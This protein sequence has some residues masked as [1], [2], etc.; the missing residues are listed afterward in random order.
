MQAILI[1][2]TIINL[3]QIMTVRFVENSPDVAHDDRCSI[4]FASDPGSPYEIYGNDAREIY[5]RVAKTL[6]ITIEKCE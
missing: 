4:V 1:R 6:G 3:D 5:E 2:D